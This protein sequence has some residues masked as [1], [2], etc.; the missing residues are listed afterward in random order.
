MLSDMRAGDEFRQPLAIAIQALDVASSPAELMLLEAAAARSYWSAWSTLSVH[1]VS[2]DVS[3]IPAH[4]RVFGS[5]NSP[6]TDAPRRAA[7]PANALLNYAYALLEAECRIAALAVGLDPGMGVLHADQRQRDSLVLDLMEPLRPAIDAQV[8][9]LLASRKFAAR[10][11]AETS[12]GNC[13]LVPPLPQALAA[14]LP[15]IQKMVAPVAEQ[16]ARSLLTLPRT[17]ELKLPTPL[18]QANRRAGRGA[19]K[20]EPTRKPVL[21]ESRISR[22]CGNCG[23]A[24]PARREYC[25]DCAHVLRERQLAQLVKAGPAH[26]QRMRAAGIDPTATAAARQKLKESAARRLAADAAWDAAHGARADA[27][28][29]RD[30]IFPLLGGISLGE[31]TR[32][33]GL[34]LRQSSRIQRG[35]SVPHARHWLALKQLGMK[36]E[37]HPV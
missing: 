27:D 37:A 22:V 30:Q 6:L 4:W 7:N 21:V 10:E 16:I 2:K 32:A 17:R 1:F 19:P 26:L 34:S 33:T 24:V 8:L 3:D 15:Q 5:R 28:T 36:A 20:R 9:A 12:A 18:T 25:D 14:M 35:L 11:F 13:R 23:A 29:Y 31:I